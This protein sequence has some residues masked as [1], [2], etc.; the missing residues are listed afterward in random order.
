MTGW[1]PQHT[2]CQNGGVLAVSCC[3]TPSSA[4]LPNWASQEHCQKTPLTAFLPVTKQ[5]VTALLRQGLYSSKHSSYTRGDK[6]VRT[7][8]VT[9]QH[10]TQHEAQR[11]TA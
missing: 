10:Q 1:D 8:G 11:G 9:L 4:A 6:A 2:E 3:Y 5:P 7:C